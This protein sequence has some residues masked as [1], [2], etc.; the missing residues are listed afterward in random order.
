MLSAVPK[1]TLRWQQFSAPRAP[2]LR[3]HSHNRWHAQWPRCL[4]TVVATGS[5]AARRR[6]CCKAA[7]TLQLLPDEAGAIL[8]LPSIT[9]VTFYEGTVDAEILRG[10]SEELVRANPWLAGELRRDRATGMV[11]LWVPGEVQ[12]FS[13]HFKQVRREALDM[14]MPLMDM[15][16][17][18]EDLT[19]KPGIQCVDVGP[20]EPLFT[21]TLVETKSNNFFALVVSMSHVLGD[22]FTYYRLYGALDQRPAMVNGVTYM[23]NQGPAR[24]RLNPF[25][26]L[27]F[28][29]AVAEALGPAQAWASSKAARW[30]SL[31]DG[32]LRP[33]HRWQA[34]MVDATWVQQ[35]KAAADAAG[36]AG[37]VSSNDV[38][39][40]WFLNSH[41]FEYGIMSM[42]FRNRLCG[43][44][45]THAGNY[46]A[47]LNFWPQD[48]A[49]PQGIRKALQ[50]PPYFRAQRQDVP[51][52]LRSVLGRVGVATNWASVYQELSLQNC[53]QLLHLPVLGDVQ[54]HGAMIIFQP[55]PKEL[56]IVLGER[57][58]RPRRPS[59]A[60]SQ[61]IA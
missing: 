4:T 1:E 20:S 9:T 36:G 56:G 49:S 22:G 42:N 55:K 54:V 32:W 19:V 47:G 24:A 34:W 7:G 8:M 10:M 23:A 25:R 28:V 33:K 60:V 30:G 43:L 3:C 29:E 12:D 61:R 2:R 6:S 40:S 21:I 17:S 50:N 18:L 57:R 14:Q 38:L 41:R 59:L 27:S 51:G 53:R 35:Q 45:Q 48:F 16:R 46:T 39:T 31:L 15:R 52:L 5:L 13:K 58:R 37:F 11:S 44:N 26:K